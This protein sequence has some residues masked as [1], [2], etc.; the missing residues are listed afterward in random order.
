MGL[1]VELGL[2]RHADAGDS[3]AWD[4]DDTLRPLSRKGR[5]QCE[6]LGRFLASVGYVPDVLIS[7]PKVRAR[8]TAEEVAPYL[9]ARVTID[10]RLAAGFDLPALAAVLREAGDPVRPVLVGHDPDFSWLL[11]TLCGIGAPTMR[12]GAFAL[13]ELDAVAPGAASLRWL[14][15]PD[16][17]KGSG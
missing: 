15:P 1:M 12:K 7:S 13:V 4:G 3:L 2:L 6:R 8:E 5:R 16:L 10:E 9:G 11:A 17:L 14:I